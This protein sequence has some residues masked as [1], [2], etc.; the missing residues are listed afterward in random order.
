MPSN[1]IYLSEIIVNENKQDVAWEIWQEKGVF[2]LPEYSERRCFRLEE[3]SCHFL[4]LI[5]LSSFEDVEIVTTGRKGLKTLIEPKMI[6]DWHNQIVSH[7]ESVK[8]M[9][10]KLP[11]TSKLQLRY[12][13]VPLNVYAEYI[14]WREGTIFDVVRG[15][16]DI[17][18][19]LAYHTVLSMQPGVL[20][21][22]GFEGDSKT[23]MANIFQ[24]L[25]YQKIIQEAGDQ[26]IAG[27]E[28]GLY[29][30]IFVSK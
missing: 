28:N 11:E 25:R 2:G 17:D 29:T 9:K 24:T 5:S 21:L 4:E 19:F 26:F 18:C 7:V 13:E 12:I 30:R 1:L 16:D 10:T 22:S 6:S 15:A 14:K 20:F 27:G 8:P 23:Y 3:N